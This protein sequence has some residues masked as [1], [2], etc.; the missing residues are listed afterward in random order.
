MVNPNWLRSFCTLV[1]VGHFT[2]TAE[3]LFMTQ[4]GV[5]QHI[6]KLEEFLGVSLLIREGKQF[7]LTDA[8]RRLYDESY[9]I[10]QALS[11]LG[12]RIQA[13]LPYQGEVRLMS[14]G[15]VGLRLYPRLLSLQQSHPELIIDYRFAPNSDIERSVIESDAD[16]GLI[17][18]P[19]PLIDLHCEAIAKE[20]LLLVTP[21]SVKQPDWHQLLE[22]G[23]IG[24]PDGQHHATLLLRENYAEFEHIESIEKKGFSN[25]ISLILEPV[26]RG[27]GFTV[28]PAY[29]VEAFHNR[30]A[31]MVHRLNQPVSES[32]YLVTRAK[33]NVPSRV[34]T[35]IQSCK[36][37]I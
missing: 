5:S 1:D 25:Q 3:R 27:L 8:G 4:S 29:A 32:L 11:E 16:I 26:A 19:S 9:P 30:N 35:V 6:R 15:S 24:H 28:L 7:E 33:I 34:E 37:W 10:V 21:A 12:P 18:Q 13:D 20:D 22:L 36:Q 17:T 31:V 2:R 23:F 14:P